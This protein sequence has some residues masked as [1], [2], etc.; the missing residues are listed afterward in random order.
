MDIIRIFLVEDHQIVRAGLRRMLELEPDLQVV[1]EASNGEEALEQ[2]EQLTPDIVITDIQMPRMDGIEFT[3][4]VKQ[5]QPECQVL[6]LT[7]Y[8]EY[9][10]SALQA[11]AV[12]YLLKDIH[13]EDLVSAIRSIREGRSPLHLSMQRD[14]LKSL[15]SGGA[16][17][18]S[19][20]EQDTLRLVAKGVTT[21][22][23]ARQ[24]SFSETTVKRTIRNVLDK[25]GV[26]NRSEAVAEAIRRNL[27]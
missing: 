25:M 1:G 9:F 16:S 26:H 3:R 6:V 22:E 27:I 8:E 19:E 13:R 10:E 2:L 23:I 18:L 21:D 20:R 12:G 24:L 15:A 17:A 14:R 7:M 11:G 5:E 4:R